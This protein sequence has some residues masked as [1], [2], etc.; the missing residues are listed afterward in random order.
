M[1]DAVQA[2]AQVREPSYAQLRSLIEQAADGIFVADTDGRY[3]FVNEAGCRMLGFSREEIV[4]KTIPDLI[5]PHDAERLARSREQMLGGA[6]HVDEWTLR[7]KDGTWLPVEVSAKIL[8]DGQWQAFV[9]DISERR[10]HDAERE[11]LFREV[12][13]E[14]R[15]LRAVLDTL[16]LGVILYQ[17]GRALSFNAAAERILGTKLSPAGGTAQYAARVFYPDGRPVPAVAGSSEGPRPS[18]R[19]PPS[20]PTG[21]RTSR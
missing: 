1:S 3:T 17:P 4:G 9:R 11:A 10:A 19:S 14:R 2:M 6:S 7:R 16:P 8:P 13:A 12:D 18:G 20:A 15:W 21:C 5:P